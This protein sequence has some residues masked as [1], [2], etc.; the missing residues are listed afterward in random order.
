[1]IQAKAQGL[2]IVFA[3]TPDF[4][5]QQLRSLLASEHE[6]VAV[7]T[8]PDR[9]AGRGKKLTASPVKQLAVEHGI[10]VHQPPTLKAA[11]A[12]AELAELN[13]DIM[14][15]VAYGLLLP[16]AV[17]NI[18]RLGCINIHAS[19]L[20][21]WRGAAPIQRAIEAGDTV[22]GITIM[23][24]DAGLDTGDMLVKAE[25][26]IRA[27][28]TAATLHDRLSELA[29]PATITALQQLQSGQ[30]QPKSQDDSKST[31]AAKISKAEAA[32]DWRRPAQELERQVRA[33]NPFPIAFMRI[34]DQEAPIRVWAAE[35]VD[36]DA[37]ATPATIIAVA[38]TG[39]DIACGEGMLRLTTLQ[40]PGKKALPIADLLRGHPDLFAPGQTLA[41]P[42]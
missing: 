38:P 22:S 12:Q 29:G 5:A 19:L 33:F 40:L 4:A 32:L 37:S 2:R 3:G 36:A 13:A 17:L 9:P 31:Y 28:D 26:P 30:A 10:P 20:P 16:Q 41:L 35:V 18:P 6:L 15:V 21:R 25:C 27:D 7:Y 8:Q 34:P 1:M 23:Q 11:Q 39:L 14:V 42:Q 24:M